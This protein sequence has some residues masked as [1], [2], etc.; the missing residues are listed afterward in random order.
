MRTYT[1]A[2]TVVYLRIHAHNRGRRQWSEQG[3]PQGSI[4]G[5][6]LFLCFLDK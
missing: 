5:P 2:R 4:L 3:V 1:Y 6:V